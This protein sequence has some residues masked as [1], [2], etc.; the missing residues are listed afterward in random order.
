MCHIFFVHSSVH[1]HADRFRVLA[2]VNSAAVDIGGVHLFEAQFSLGIYPGL[3]LLSHVLV[4]S[5]F[6]FLRNFE[7]T[8]KVYFH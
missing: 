8:F 3:G 4:L 5:I 1:R 6:S 2:V 7:S